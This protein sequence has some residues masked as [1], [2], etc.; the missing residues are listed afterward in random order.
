[1]QHW[2]SNG[3]KTDI[4]AASAAG[5]DPG[6]AT[7]KWLIGLWLICALAGTGIT[8][9]LAQ[10]GSLFPSEPRFLDV[11]EAFRFYT[12]LDSTDQ[13]SVHWTIAPG[14][15]LYDEKFNFQVIAP[16]GAESSV[17]AERP[18]GI[19]HHDEFFG[20]VDVHYDQLRTIIPLPGN[21]QE[22]FEL[23][24]GFQGCAEAG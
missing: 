17:E 7:H 1:M 4:R 5:A 8:G 18:D 21:Y 22:P 2:Y 11:D 13:I 6:G 20:D 10:T 15:Y 3:T 24:V 9:A 12:S 23:I 16:N 19:A 14:Y